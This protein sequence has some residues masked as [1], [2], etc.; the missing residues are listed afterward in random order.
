MTVKVVDEK[1][2]SK[3]GLHHRRRLF[4][5]INSSCK[6]LRYEV[7]EVR[8]EKATYAKGY[9]KILTIN[10]PDNAIIIQLDFRRNP[11][12]I[13]KGDIYIFD[14]KGNKLGRAVYRKLKVRLIE[15]STASVLELL[16]C[17][18]RKLKLPVKKYGIIKS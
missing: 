5:V 10:T 6:E 1:S 7:K 2:K 3:S 17:V 12:G 9:L 16:K 4:F 18:F 8:E 13:I 15:Y 14:C 11:R